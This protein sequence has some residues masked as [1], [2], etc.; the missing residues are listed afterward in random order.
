MQIE[1]RK[2]TTQLELRYSNGNSLRIAVANAD[3]DL[4]DTGLLGS[5]SSSTV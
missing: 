5:G 4:L 3:A 2:G 1:K